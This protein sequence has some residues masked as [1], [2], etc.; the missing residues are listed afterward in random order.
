MDP[1]VEL[2]MHLPKGA[3]LDFVIAWLAGDWCLSEAAI[4]IRACGA[5]SAQLRIGEQA[6]TVQS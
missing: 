4:L 3:G 5:K 2:V 1:S 6:W